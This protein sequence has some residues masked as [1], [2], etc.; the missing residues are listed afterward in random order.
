MGSCVALLSLMLLLYKMGNDACPQRSMA[1]GRGMPRNTSTLNN[2]GEV[3]ILSMSVHDSD[4]DD[5]GCPLLNTSYL[6][7]TSLS[8]LHILMH[9]VFFKH[10]W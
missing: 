3:S 6:L 4:D 1:S 9:L 8:I 2:L 7:H 10:A 5:T